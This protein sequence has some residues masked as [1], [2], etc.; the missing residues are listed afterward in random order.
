MWSK[1]MA[2]P[3]M[4]AAW[5]KGKRVAFTGRLASLTRR[6]AADLTREYG[7]ENSRHVTAETS[8]LVVGQEGWPL[9]KDGRLTSKLQKAISLQRTGSAIVILPEQE[10][11]TKLGLETRADGIRRL[12]STAELSELLKVPRDR[13]RAWVRTGLVQPI[14]TAHGVWYFDFRQTAGAKTLCELADRGVSL[15]RIRKSLRQL[16]AWTSEAERTLAQL[17]LLERD[18]RL[19][20][21]LEEGQ[22]AEPTG[23][24]HLEFAKDSD[25]GDV[26]VQVASASHSADWFEL[27]CAHEQAGRFEEALEAYRQALLQNG[28]DADTCFNLANVLYA[29]GRPEQALERFWQVVELSPGFAGAWNNLG[30][31]LAELGHVDESIQAFERALQVGPDYADAHYNLADV[32]EHCGRREEARSHW[33][34]YLERE[35]SGPW[36]K[37][38]R[39][40][41]ATP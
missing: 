15:A 10:L 32:L 9:R 28:P 18:G 38:A 2:E 31:L 6:E 41:L 40:R 26:S 36:A 20:V 8:L 17:A 23:Q 22:L 24:L 30:N 7:A 4:D 1:Q 35:P 27:G 37:Y 13:I 29:L 25:D 16:R 3:A 5:L 11:L 33:Q 19:L 12:Y 14:E 34:R 39:G 21:R